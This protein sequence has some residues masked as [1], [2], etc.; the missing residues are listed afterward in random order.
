MMYNGEVADSYNLGSINT[1][2]KPKG[3]DRTSV[4]MGG[5]VGDTTEGSGASAVIYNV[6]NKGQ[7]GDEDYETYAR[8]VG[9]IVG[10]LSGIVDNHIIQ[11]LYITDI[12]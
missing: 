2:R 8:H 4:N 9:G 7:I 1:T 12:V 3:G 6:Y 11:V 10:R 5:V